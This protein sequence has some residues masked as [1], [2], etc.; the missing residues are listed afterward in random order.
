MGNRPAEAET[1]VAEDVG[2]PVEI[3]IGRPAGNLDVVPTAAAEYPV[4]VPFGF[5]NPGTTV[6]WG[7]IVIVMPV[8]FNPFSDIS[9]HVVKI[10]FIGIFTGDRMRGGSSV[11][12]VPRLFN[13]FSGIVTE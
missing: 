1:L 11:F 2:G 12:I 3:A 8:I 13:E 5:F 10:V 6:V 4:G 9:V 7:S